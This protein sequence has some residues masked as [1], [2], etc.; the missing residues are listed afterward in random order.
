MPCSIKLKNGNPCPAKVTHRW[1]SEEW[2][3]DFCCEHF[4]LFTE[5]LLDWAR[6]RDITEL[7]PNHIEI[8]SEYTRQCHRSSLSEGSDCESEKERE[9]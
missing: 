3:V 7:K 1:G 2:H 4:D 5:G 6:R 8:V 9:P